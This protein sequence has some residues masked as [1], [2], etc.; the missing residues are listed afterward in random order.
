MSE[1]LL[2]IGTYTQRMGHVK[3]EPAQGVYLARLE[4]DGA[5]SLLGL[6]AQTDNPSYLALHPSRRFLYAANETPGAEF[7]TAFA[8]DPASHLLTLLNRQPSHGGAPCHVEVEASGKYLFLANYMGGNVLAYPILPDGSLGQASDDVP[9]RGYG[10][11]PARQANSHA[12]SIWMSPDGRF[13][14]RWLR[15][16]DNAR[17]FGYKQ[18]FRLDTPGA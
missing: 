16:I 9:Q 8:V 18:E 7:V 4:R 10:P 3:G 6:A 15:W 14:P 1:P 17:R 2:Y 5:L 12:H 11:D 13:V